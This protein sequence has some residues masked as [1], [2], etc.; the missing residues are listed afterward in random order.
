MVTNMFTKLG[1]RMSTRKISTKKMLKKEKKKVPNRSP[2][3][4]EYH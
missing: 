3:V 4:E 1:K 2:R